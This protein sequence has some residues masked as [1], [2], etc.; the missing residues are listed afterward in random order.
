MQVG[1]WGEVCSMRAS[2]LALA[3]SGGSELYSW[4]EGG[5][6]YSQNSFFGQRERNTSF[7]G[8]VQLQLEVFLSKHNLFTVSWMNLLN[9]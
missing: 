4:G 1:V 7:A 5:T 2:N 6:V 8:P 3:V 9:L